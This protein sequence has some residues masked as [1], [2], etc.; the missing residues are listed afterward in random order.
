MAVQGFSLQIPLL[1]LCIC[2]FLYVSACGPMYLL[3]LA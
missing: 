2:F 1:I 3:L